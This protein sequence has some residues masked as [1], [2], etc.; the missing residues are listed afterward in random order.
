MI[1]AKGDIIICNSTCS[2]AESFFSFVP[3]K[4]ACFIWIYWVWGRVY[5]EHVVWVVFFL[6][7]FRFFWYRDRCF[8]DNWIWK[9]LSK[10]KRRRVMVVS[11][12][13]DS[14]SESGTTEFPSEEVSNN[15]LLVSSSNV[16]CVS[17]WV[18]LGYP[19]PNGASDRWRTRGL[20]PFGQRIM[21]KV[22]VGVVYRRHDWMCSMN[23]EVGEIE[24]LYVK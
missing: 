2:S 22:F 18:V 3:N 23:N 11:L 19:L 24:W 9:K 5:S 15:A 8:W 13:V 17:F 20:T 12:P 4:W 1:Q 21:G 6:Y 14:S 10:R 16:S 7:M